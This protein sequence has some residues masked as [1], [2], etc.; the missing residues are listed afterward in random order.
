MFPPP[1][2]P[3]ADPFALL[4]LQF[5]EVLGLA[6]Q[7]QYI[8][9]VEFQHLI[10]IKPFGNHPPSLRAAVVNDGQPHGVGSREKSNGLAHMSCHDS[11]R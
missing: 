5:R 11:S 7:A 9:A 10:R 4:D 8:A 3:R 2:E 1:D 6:P